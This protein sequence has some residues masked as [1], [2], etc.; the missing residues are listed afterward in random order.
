MVIK[1]GH[2]G[3]RG[4][5]L[6]NSPSSIKKALELPID[7]IEIDVRKCKTGEIVV[8]HDE[9]VDR[10]TNGEGEVRN[11]SLK[12]LKELDLINGEKILTL[13]EALS[14][15]D[16]NKKINI[17]LKGS[18]TAKL[19][20]KIIKNHLEKGWGKEDFLVTSFM[21][22]RLQRMRERKLKIGTGLIMIIS[23]LLLNV[24]VE[25]IDTEF[26]ILRKEFIN[27]EIIK[28]LHSMGTR[29]IAWVVNRKEEIERIKEL[30]IDGII[31]DYPERI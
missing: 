26:M 9:T 29:V 14:I 15:I 30:G 25:K 12:E 5:E 10:V 20:S 4:Y 18:G 2:R 22:Y 8:I 13:N 3:A 23:P 28:D 21:Y 16:R 7:M 24:P 27:K 31:S 19:V 11:K 1:I 6:E 17:E